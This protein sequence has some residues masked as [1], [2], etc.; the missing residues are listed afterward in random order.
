MIIGFITNPDHILREVV[1]NVLPVTTM[2]NAL[3]GYFYF[4]EFAELH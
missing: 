3:V 2:F 4:Q 1:N